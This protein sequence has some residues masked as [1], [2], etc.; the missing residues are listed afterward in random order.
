MN[1]PDLPQLRRAVGFFVLVAATLGTTPARAACDAQPFD[2]VRRSI[3]GEQMWVNGVSLSIAE[4]PSI[5]AAAARDRFVDYW[6]RANLP[7]RTKTD[8]GVEVTS[9]LKGACLYSLQLP[10]GGATAAAPVFAVTDLRRP[11]PTL[12]HEF[13]WPLAAEG[14]LLTDTVSQDDDKLSRLLTYRVEKSSNLAAG[15]CIRRLQQADWRLQGLT[16][17]NEQ[18]FVFH[19]RKRQTSVDVTIARDGTGS[20]VTMNF[21]KSDG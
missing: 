8:A 9:V 1:R 2:G 3:V 14:E 19:G 13:D 10:A 21:L 17:I 20:V 18:H 16:Q 11:V 4:L 7:A 6:R 5:E 15:Q 12:P